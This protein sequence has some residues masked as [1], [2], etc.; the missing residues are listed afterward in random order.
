MYVTVDFICIGGIELFAMRKSEINKMKNSLPKR[1]SNPLCLASY[2]GT[3]TYAIL[4]LTVD[5]K[6]LEAA[7]TN[8]INR[9]NTCFR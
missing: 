1:N 9:E 3:L 8:E 7:N 4:K 5:I 2:T 6:L